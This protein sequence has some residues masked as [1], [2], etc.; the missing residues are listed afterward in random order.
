M[1]LTR[2]RNNQVYNSDINAA[3][4]LQPASITGGLLAAN[5]TYS[6]NLTVG[7]L[8]V[9]GLTTTVDTTNLIIADPLVVVNRNQSGSPSYDLGFIFGRGNQT[10][11]AMIWEETAQ[12]FQLQYTTESTAGTTFGT[13]NNSG[14]AN[15]QAYGVSLNNATI[16]TASLTTLNTSGTITASGNIW[17]ASATVSTTPTTGALVVTGGIGVSGAIVANG[18]IAMQGNGTLHSDS[19]LVVLFNSSP[20]T[21]L[22]AFQAVSSAIIGS[23]SGFWVIRNQTLFGNNATQNLYNTVATTMNF[24]SAATS[25]NMGATSGTANIANPTV[26]GSQTTQN[27]YNTVATT[28]NFGG[29]ATSLNMGAATGTATINNPTLSLPN[30]T[31]VLMNGANPTIDTSATGTASLFNAN[32]TTVNIGGAATTVS[33]GANYGRTNI[34][35]DAIADNFIVNSSSGQFIGNMQGAI[36]AN[37]PNTG[38]F[39]SITTT[40]TINSQ[41][42]ISAP[43]INAGTIGNSGAALTAST[44]TLTGTANSYGAGQGALQ[45]TGGFY[46]GGDSYINGSLIVGNLIA[47]S[48]QILTVQEPLLYLSPLGTSSYNYDIGIYSHFVVGGNINNYQHTGLV[49]NYIDNDWYLF[50]NAAEPTGNVVNLASA[51]LVYDTLKL[52]AVLIQNTTTAS[53]T[54]SGALQVAGGAGI[55]GA[56]Y[57]G[58]IQNTPIGSSTASTGAFTTLTTSSTITSQGTITGA[59]QVIGYLNGIIGANTANSG[60]FTTVTTTG[61]LYSGGNIVA[62]SGTSSTSTTTGALVVNGGIGISGNIYSA[63][64]T[65]IGTAFNYTP[66]FAKFQYGDNQNNYVQIVVQNQNSGNQATT[67]IVAVANNGSDND[68]FID[69]GINSS[70]YNQTAYNLTGPNDGYLYVTGNTSTG[71]GNLVISTYTLN[72]II[73][74]LSG[75]AIAN[76]IGRFRANTN[77]FVVSS[78]TASTTASTGALIINGGAGINGTINT[79]GNINGASSLNVNNSYSSNYY[80]Y[81]NSGDINVYTV[82]NSN[83][84]VNFSKL[85][86]NLVVHGAS[87]SGYQNLLV[88]NGVTGQVGIKIAP[89]QITGNA[90]LQINSTDSIILP[91]GSTAQRPSNGVAGMFRY[92]NNTNQLEYYSAGSSSWVSASGAYTTVSEDSFTGDGSTVAFTLSQSGTTN[93]VIVS[94]NGLVQIPITAY[95]VSGTTLTFTEAPL[96]TDIIDAR[97]IVST[98]VVTSIATGTSVIGLQDSG[99]GTGNVYINTN[100]TYRYIANTA[101]GGS[102]YFRGGIAPMMNPVALTNGANTIVDSFSAST[103]TGAKYLI[104]LKATSGAIQNTELLVVSNA[105]VSNYSLVSNV[106]IGA[107]VATVGANVSGGTVYIVAQASTSGATATFMPTYMPI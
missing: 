46:A 21:T 54:T 10:N 75:S 99:A 1:A 67:D 94:V 24:A 3:T 72:D 97:T 71:G 76:E 100:G 48:Q 58:S 27:L 51:G 77:S 62:A 93:S 44:A 83:L 59:G 86:A 55:A 49:R 66:Q 89:N 16:G 81:A 43:T 36:G 41:G 106:Y 107:G 52:G 98:S 6:G 20:T 69:F 25:L 64:S 104:K 91:S 19:T 34:N 35:N 61:N 7:N 32:A 63:G 4:K 60:A 74:S 11:T 30:G 14:Y 88:T 68:T 102:N 73:F 22:S 26:I 85:A 65:F 84:N 2:I 33:I 101:T 37:I 38:A 5:F 17:A 50:S 9:S 31:L 45:I 8:T 80:P 47:S 79:G 15:L 53:S 56:L 13:I 78:T 28:L 12:Q 23:N 90:S 95:S 82:G 92:N 103:F 87:T 105:T 96:A 39:T 18:G 57:A 70:G 29:A 40:G 42:T